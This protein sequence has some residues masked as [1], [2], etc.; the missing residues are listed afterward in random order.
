MFDLMIPK[1][2]KTC[3]ST[4]QLVGPGQLV[5]SDYLLFG[6]FSFGIFL[7]ISR[8]IFGVQLSN[9]PL[10]HLP[11][12][13]FLSTFAFHQLGR[14]LFPRAQLNRAGLIFWLWPFCLLG[15]YATVG[16]LLA[17]FVFGENE[18]FLTLGVYLLATPFFF[19]WGR[20][21]SSAMKLVGPLVFIW[22]TSSVVAIAGTLARYG[23][24]ESLHEIEFWVLPFFLYSYFAAKTLQGR[25]LSVLALTFTSILT[26]KL[27]GYVV[28][29]GAV[30]Y[31]FAMQIHNSV[32]PKWRALIMGAVAMT[33]L[34]SL[35]LLTLGFL[36]FEQ[37]LPSGNVSVR[38]HQYELAL[39]SFINSPIWGKA[40]TGSS[41]EFFV[42]YTKIINLPTHSDLLDLLKQ[43]GLIAFA[44]WTIGIFRS[45]KLF[46]NYA[47]RS[48]GL[49][50][51]FH[52]MTYMTGAIVF[53]CAVNPLLL[54]PPFAFV[55]W[56][57]LSLAI[58][59]ATNNGREQFND[60]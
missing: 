46:L 6:A 4:G 47:L 56:G 36:Y 41:G 52:A 15:S 9:S 31:I 11:L 51:F 49:S 10:K 3:D 16:S 57:M 18:T 17:K 8:P 23:Q 38:L 40:Y 13:L 12:A 60:S 32:E 5:F 14:T 7:L 45:I 35:G 19:I 30:G 44:F 27:T 39:A 48:R 22:G 50:A 26:Q 43:G 54:K 21:S 28:G 59:V 55:I 29:I 58:S 24:D 34:I 37:Y 33:L 20:T 53:S 25:V 42:E 1:G 2:V